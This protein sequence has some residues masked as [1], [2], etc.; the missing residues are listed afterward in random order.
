MASLGHLKRIWKGAFRV[1]GAVQETHEVDVL[2]GTGVAFART[3]CGVAF[4]PTQGGGRG[5][6][7]PRVGVN[8]TP[9]FVW[10][11]QKFQSPDRIFS[12]SDSHIHVLRCKIHFKQI[13]DAGSSVVTST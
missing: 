11:A 3:S 12:G 10:E 9:A 13:E 6:C 4:A 7:D 5:E 2:G 8:V 1:A